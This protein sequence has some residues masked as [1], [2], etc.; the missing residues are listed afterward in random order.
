[1]PFDTPP[2]SYR[3]PAPGYVVPA[4]RACDAVGSALRKAFV[5]DRSLPDPLA[6][7]LL[8]LDCLG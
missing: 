3:M 7:A 4:P 2:P 5:G 6:A 1:M 8:K